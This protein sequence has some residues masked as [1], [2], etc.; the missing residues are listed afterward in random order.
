[1]YHCTKVSLLWIQEWHW[2]TIRQ[3][4]GIGF[5][6][7]VNCI[8][9]VTDVLKD[10]QFESFMET[11]RGVEKAAN[12]EKDTIT[13]MSEISSRYANLS[14]QVDKHGNA[15]FLV[16]HPFDALFSTID[17]DL[18]AIRTLQTSQGMEKFMSLFRDLESKLEV[19]QSVLGQWENIQ[20]TVISVY[21]FFE[22]EEVRLELSGELKRFKL[23]EAAYRSII[24]NAQRHQKLA[25]M[26]ELAP[27]LPNS[28]DEMLQG[29]KSLIVD[30]QGWLDNKRVAFPRL[31][32]VSDEELLE[33]VSGSKQP[34][35]VKHILQRYD[36]RHG[37]VPAEVLKPVFR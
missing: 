5:H 32:F 36:F 19:A 6:P 21:K 13:T 7:T 34:Q 31:F 3:K 29:L 30:V 14:I 9:N 10:G 15:R 28:L 25:K 20:K 1:M 17:S 27:D 26:I 37:A 33:L 18:L 2:D 11:I 22:S 8:K 35:K 24:S 23:I 16:A 12:K 4:L